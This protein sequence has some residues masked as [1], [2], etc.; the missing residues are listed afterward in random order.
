MSSEKTLPT[1]AF[2]ASTSDDE[3]D[4]YIRKM[5]IDI[6]SNMVKS[7][8]S[9]IVGIRK[10]LP[11]WGIHGISK[12]CADQLWFHPTTQTIQFPM[13]HYGWS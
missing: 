6:S 4:E 1:M 7:G 9:T 10:P 8:L 2:T 11:R 5:V 3:E 12:Y 13:L